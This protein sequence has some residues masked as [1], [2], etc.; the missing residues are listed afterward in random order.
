M[1]DGN[2]D[3]SELIDTSGN[4]V[5]HYE[6]DSFGKIIVQSG[7][8]AD[9]NPLRFSSEY[10][11]TETGLVYYNYRYYNPDLGRWLSKDPI[12]ERGGY[13]LYV[14]VGNNIINN[15]DFIGLAAWTESDRQRE[16][17]SG[18]ESCT[19]EQDV[20]NMI[21]IFFTK[22]ETFKNKFIE[23]GLDASTPPDETYKTI[24]KMMLLYGPS[25][26]AAVENVVKRITE[27]MTSLQLHVT[28]WTLN[29]TYEAERVFKCVCRVQNGVKS[30]VWNT[31]SF[32][33][34]N[35]TKD[36]TYDPK[37]GGNT[38]EMEEYLKQKITNLSEILAN[39]AMIYRREIQ[40]EVERY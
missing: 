38:M 27:N 9:E 29:V 5:A 10:F 3:V 7:A 33:I 13:N 16:V 14:I 40:R 22:Q 12:G 34:I 18:S 28:R 11:D 24:R 21:K 8:Y 36:W 4:V 39:M 6:Y 32:K 35:E 23:K 17:I 2:K 26:L 15:F 37:E 31:V 20:G 1:L 25:R 30:Y 19:G